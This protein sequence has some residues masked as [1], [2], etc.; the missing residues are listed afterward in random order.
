MGF[1]FAY[2]VIKTMIVV[3]VAGTIPVVVQIADWRERND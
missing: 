2:L 1:L 3:I